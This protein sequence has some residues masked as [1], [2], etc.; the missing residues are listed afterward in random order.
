MHAGTPD[1]LRRD[2]PQSIEVSQR[3][4]HGTQAVAIRNQRV[5]APSGQ[6]RA[7]AKQHREHRAARSRNQAAEGF[8]EIHMNRLLLKR[9]DI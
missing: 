2:Q 5:H 1:G 3:L 7:S 4:L 9:T 8:T 6:G